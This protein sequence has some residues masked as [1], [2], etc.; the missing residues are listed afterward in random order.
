M[1]DTSVQIQILKEL[2]DLIKTQSDSMRTLS[3][4]IE[5]ESSSLKRLVVYE[6][7]L[8]EKREA[9]QEINGLFRTANAQLSGKDRITFEFYVQTAYFTKVI[10]EANKRLS[11]M[12]QGRYAMVLR[13]G[14]TDR[15]NVTGLDLDVIDFH[16]NK[17]REVSTLSGGESFKAALSL[18]LGMSDVIQI[19]AGGI[20][21]DMLFVDEGFG[22][23][24]Q[25]S[26]DQAI[27]VLNDLSSDHRLIG[28]IS[29]VSELKERI[30]KQIIVHKDITGSSVELVV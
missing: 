19:F 20:E 27:E 3:S 16:T 5:K 28:I 8:I 12:T 25:E 6:K 26:L 14:S 17:T 1:P 2:E 24:D 13:E 11:I 18:A 15:R 23:L 9:Y 4:E 10:H 21:I 30:H 7:R 29:H 22:S